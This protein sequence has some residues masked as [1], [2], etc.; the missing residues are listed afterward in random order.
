[1]FNIN[2]VLSAQTRTNSHHIFHPIQMKHCVNVILKSFQI[3]NLTPGAPKH[4]IEVKLVNPPKNEFNH[5][6]H[7][8]A[9]MPMGLLLPLILHVQFIS[10]FG[11][12]KIRQYNPQSATI[13]LRCCIMYH[14]VLWNSS[15]NTYF[16]LSDLTIDFT[17]FC[18]VYNDCKYLI[19]VNDFS[20]YS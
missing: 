11:F 4:L 2:I 8:S 9:L 5:W 16:G 12:L 15:I 3:R 10:S 14:N 6:I 17:D 7:V 13:S 20:V 1:M 19:S 18:L